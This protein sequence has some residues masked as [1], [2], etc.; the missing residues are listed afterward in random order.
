VHA[1]QTRVKGDRNRRLPG[2]VLIKRTTEQSPS[3]ESEA[4]ISPT[5]PPQSENTTEVNTKNN[6]NVNATP[7][8][9]EKP[10]AEEKESVSQISPLPPHQSTESTTPVSDS[11]SSSSH[12]S[13]RLDNPMGPQF[14]NFALL[15]AEALQ[16][17]KQ[18][19]Q[20]QQQ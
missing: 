5:T 1:T 12:T 10:I 18:Q 11:P 6:P 19:Q 3:A 7:E 17:R 9:K 20:Q 4:I 2:R 16:K 13:R 15:A 14:Q 8:T